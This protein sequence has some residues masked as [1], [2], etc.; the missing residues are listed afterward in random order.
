MITKNR[1]QH[2]TKAGKRD[3]LDKMTN[4]KVKPAEKV[5]KASDAASLQTRM[6]PVTKACKGTT[7]KR[8]IPTL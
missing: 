2:S 8:N 4:I 7:H 5:A 1:M 6:K 3:N